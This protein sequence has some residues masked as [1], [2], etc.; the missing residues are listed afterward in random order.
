M[1]T[2]EGHRRW[3]EARKTSGKPNSIKSKVKTCGKCA[4][5]RALWRFGDSIIR[6]RKWQFEMAT[7][8]K[9]YLF[10][11]WNQHDIDALGRIEINKK[12]QQQ[13]TFLWKSKTSWRAADVRWKKKW[14]LSKYGQ[15]VIP[16]GR[17]CNHLFRSQTIVFI[18]RLLMMLG[19]YNW[20]S[21]R[22]IILLW[23]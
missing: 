1:N 6:Y 22:L 8:T 13:N 9:W 2:V 4:R 20:M 19:Q 21:R 10:V 11:S 17:D 15:S 23:V 16:M 18:A 14:N 7:E 5:Q 3:E 12:Q